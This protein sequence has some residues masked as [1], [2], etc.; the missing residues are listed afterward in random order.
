[1]PSYLAT[2]RWNPN[3]E[4]DLSGYKLYRRTSIFLPYGSPTTLA[5][6]GGAGTTGA[7]VAT[8]NLPNLAT[9]YLVLTAFDVTG[10][11]STNS[12]EVNVSVNLPLTNIRRTVK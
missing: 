11:E 9:H 4:P 6:N 2:L 1:M 7:P 8:V 3:V 5:L 10:N 12:A